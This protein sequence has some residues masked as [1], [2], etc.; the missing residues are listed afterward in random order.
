MYNYELNGTVMCNDGYTEYYDDT[1]L[2]HT[3]KY[4]N[5]TFGH[6]CNC[7]V[8]KILQIEGK[9]SMSIYDIKEYLIN[10]YGFKCMK[11]EQF[12]IHE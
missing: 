1:L 3:V 7:A 6:M 5:K 4:D 8:S 2:C 9:F 12:F 10:N 11:I